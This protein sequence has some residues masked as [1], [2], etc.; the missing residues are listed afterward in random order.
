[1]TSLGIAGWSLHR[2]I[3][4]GQLTLLD[5]PALAVTE[6]GVSTIELNS[7][8]FE[9]LEKSYLLELRSRADQ[10]GVSI[11]QIAVDDPQMD[12]SS[13]DVDKRKAGITCAAE[14]LRASALLGAKAC[15]LNMDDAAFRTGAD[16]RGAPSEGE[17]LASIASF[18][19]LVVTAERY[20]VTMTIE[21]HY[22]ISAG[23]ESI[24]RFIREVDSP[25]LGTCPDFGNFA[26]EKRYEE[27]ARIIPFAVV[28][29]AKMHDFDESGNETTMDVPRIVD[30]LKKA[31]FA[32]EYL[33][34]YEGPSDEFEG[35]RQSLRL[36]QRLFKEP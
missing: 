5:F 8:F 3:R 20:A 13:L 7:P 28:T 34:E 14:W 29:H 36:L 35:T 33:V 12:L 22:G 23:A 16:P 30:M 27:L 9:S 31:G 32:G 21:N 15:R 2:T 19:E 25:F 4:E 18:Q 1:V 10:A 11:V 24:V 17:I 26:A 6:F